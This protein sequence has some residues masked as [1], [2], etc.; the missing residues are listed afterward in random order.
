MTNQ[1]QLL[2]GMKNR[3]KERQRSLSIPVFVLILALFGLLFV[4]WFKGRQNLDLGVLVKT[5]GG[6]FFLAKIKKKEGDQL[7]LER[8]SR[9]V[10]R[11]SHAKKYI[12]NEKVTE[13]IRISQIDHIRFT[14]IDLE[15]LIQKKGLGGNESESGSEFIPPPKEYLGVYDVRVS[16]H[17][18]ILY[19]RIRNNKLKGTLR[20]PKW[21]KGSW[22]RC[23]SIKI[24]G[25]SLFFIRSVTSPKERKRVGA[26]HFFKQ[27][28]RAR[29][30]KKGKKI[31]GTYSL[32][33]ERTSW[34]G[35]KRH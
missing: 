1:E 6:K 23:K 4:C 26:P 16:G 2:P 8:F 13:K 19:L 7:V 29:F 30:Y 18:G 33:K 21:A 24:R 10:K 14:N 17:K 20:F 31:V 22:E 15:K 25:N 3:K 9:D 11:S 5:T 28:Y 34:E 32:G 27:V 35:K 12:L